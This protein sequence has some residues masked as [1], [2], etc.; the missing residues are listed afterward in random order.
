MPFRTIKEIPVARSNPGNGVR[1]GTGGAIGVG[2]G[3]ARY[4]VMFVLFILC[5]IPELVDGLWPLWD[6]K[7]QTW[8]DKVVKSVVVDA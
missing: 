8:H 5:V 4:G 3:L 1:F 7:R 2:A 6:K